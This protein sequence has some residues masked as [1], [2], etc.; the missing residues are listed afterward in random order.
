MTSPREIYEQVFHRALSIQIDAVTEGRKITLEEAERQAVRELAPTLKA[1]LTQHAKSKHR[2]AEH[3]GKGNSADALRAMLDRINVDA[4]RQR[5]ALLEA[6]TKAEP[7]RKG[8]PRYRPKQSAPPVTSKAPHRSRPKLAVI[9]GGASASSYGL[10]R[11]RRFR[12][13]YEPFRSP[14]GRTWLKRNFS[15]QDK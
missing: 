15:E 1:Q 8:I 11:S 14:D 12:P 2:P 4:V 13:R 5:V 10:V 7:S 9:D 6:T 3:S